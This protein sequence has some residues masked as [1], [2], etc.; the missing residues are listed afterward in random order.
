MI[1]LTGMWSRY[2]AYFNSNVRNVLLILPGGIFVHYVNGFRF[3]S[4]Y[5]WIHSIPFH[6]MVAWVAVAT[7]WCNVSV[8]CAFCVGH[9][10]G[11]REKL[12]WVRTL[13]TTV[14]SCSF[15]EFTRRLH[16]QNYT[17]RS[18]ISFY[19][20]RRF[21]NRVSLKIMNA[22]VLWEKFDKRSLMI[23]HMVSGFVN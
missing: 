17:H 16:F 13:F 22:S 21:I 3:S 10:A 7:P 12:C 9:F 19:V 11:F 5:R 14:R 2:P 8:A 15:V 4:F 20:E 18:F 23:R 6:Q 1:F